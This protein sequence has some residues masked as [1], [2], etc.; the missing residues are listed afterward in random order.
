MHDTIE[1]TKLTYQMIVGIFGKNVADGVRD[2]SRTTV[3]GVKSTAAHTLHSLYAEGKIGLLYVKLSDRNHN[4][5]TI[6]A[7]KLDKQL[8]ISKETVSDFVP[9][10]KQMDLFELADELSNLSYKASS[11]SESVAFKEDKSSLIPMSFDF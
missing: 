10:A 6:A 1:D 9:I 8:R 4:M 11:L 7:M 3:D 2:L 5:D